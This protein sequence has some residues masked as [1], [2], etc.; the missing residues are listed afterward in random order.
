MKKQLCPLCKKILSLTSLLILLSLSPALSAAP[1]ARPAPAVDVEKVTLLDRAEG[2]NYVGT[3]KASKIVNITPKITGTLWKALFKEGSHVK[4]GDLLFEIEDTVFKANL[5]VAAAQLKQLQA[6]LDFARKEF[7]RQSSLMA[8]NATAVTNYESHLR[9]YE[10]SKAKLLEAKARMKLCEND[11]S[12]TKI[13]SPINGKIGELAIHVGNEVSPASGKLAE[14]VSYDPVKIQFAVSEKDF[15]LY[16]PNGKAAKHSIKIF[17]ADGK[18]FKGRFSFDFFD[19]QVDPATDTI[20]IQLKAHN[21][22]MELLPGGYV[23]VNFTRFFHKKLPAVPV[24]ALN[25]DGRKYFVY[26]VRKDNTAEKRFVKTGELVGG[27]QIVYQGLRP[28]EKIV[29]SGT[30]K[31]IPNG[32]IIPVE[33]ENK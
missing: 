28:G 31:I 22:N 1:P 25:F 30:H 12:Y 13:Y 14:I 10:S 9:T 27:R 7:Q 26:T 29:V 33:A 21:K 20:L 11:L 18:L 16:F 24:S 6:E 17:R 3:L 5:Q 32:K 15:F 23:T 4:K 8:S 2:K 19:N